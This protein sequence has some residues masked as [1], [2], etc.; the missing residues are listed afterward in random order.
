MWVCVGVRVGEASLVLLLV[1][2]KLHCPLS[3]NELL[4]SV[5]VTLTADVLNDIQCSWTPSSGQTGVF[6]LCVM[7][8]VL[9]L[10]LLSL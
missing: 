9:C 3:L 7:C 5:E 8:F 10:L 6:C 2:Q 4:S 1:L